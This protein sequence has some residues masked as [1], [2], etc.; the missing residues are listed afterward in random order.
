MLSH[1]TC[2]CMILCVGCVWSVVLQDH[3]L[4]YMLQGTFPPDT[5]FFVAEEDWRLQPSDTLVNPETVAQADVRKTGGSVAAEKD[6]KQKVVD[7]AG[8]CKVSLKKIHAQHTGEPSAP[9]SGGPSALSTGEPSAPGVEDSAG[10]QPHDPSWVHKFGAFY[11]RPHKPQEK[12][13]E[14]V[15]PS[16]EIEDLVRHVT[17]AHRKGVGDL[18]WLSWDGGNSKG[19]KCKPSHACTLLAVT[20]PGARK[21]QALMLSGKIRQGHFDLRLLSWLNADPKHVKEMKASYFYPSLG[22]Y[23][24]HISGCQKG[25]GL[26][27]SSFGK[28][29]VQA[30]TRKSTGGADAQ[31]RW[32]MGFIPKGLV[33]MVPIDP[34]KQS[35]ELRWLTYKPEVGAPDAAKWQEHQ[36]RTR[37]AKPP[38]VSL[39]SPSVVLKPEDRDYAFFGSKRQRRQ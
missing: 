27:P 33:C 16:Q 31:H 29:W 20:I 9:S 12:K 24:E 2:V 22:S 15:Q 5:V 25:L 32:L 4:P 14:D 3:L 17:L 18:V 36:Q 10:V 30:G 1:D 11:E 26:R 38:K 28:A 21:L 7:S 19:Q 6:G 39:V 8:P 13:S 35:T 37:G 34:D 23:T